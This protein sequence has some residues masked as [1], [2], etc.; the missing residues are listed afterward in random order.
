ML[1]LQRNRFIEPQEALKFVVTTAQPRVV[2]KKVKTAWCLEESI[3][4]TRSQWADSGTFYDTEEAYRKAFE[5][6]WA[7]A[8]VAH[9]LADYIRK[10]D[11]G[12]S[13]AGSDGDGID[14][15]SSEGGADTVEPTGEQLP[16]S[17]EPHDGYVGESS[18][19]KQDVAAT[20][21]RED[22]GEDG[23]GGRAV[24]VGEEGGA[25]AAS[26]ASG[27]AE[28]EMEV[29]ER[30]PPSDEIGD[31]IEEVKAVLWRHHKLIYS[32][33]DHYAII[34]SGSN[35][36][37]VSVGAF[38]QF[39]SDCKLAI[40]GSKHCS[41]AQFDQLFILVNTPEGGKKSAAGTKTLDRQEWLQC[42]VRCAVIR[43]VLPGTIPDVSSALDVL[44]TKDVR[45]NVHAAALQDSN[46]F[47]LG[48]CYIEQT[49]AVLL[50]HNASLRAIFDVY[51]GSDGTD[52]ATRHLAML[53]GFDEWSSL[54]RDMNWLDD[55]FTTREASFS[56]V[57]SRM[58][59]V[60]TEGSHSASKLQASRCFA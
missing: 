56:F 10:H 32:T 43:Y 36:T 3:W 39:A 17:P 29:E 12:E 34:G 22:D 9:K 28:K 54:I 35:F 58:R 16:T 46:A 4:K 42:L 57:W 23:G 40:K 25:G 11:D 7:R 60:D 47:R 18:T 37:Q 55:D 45:P 14:G 44:F 2:K 19:S 1:E 13:E 53:M 30:R 15:Q 27:D 38:K 49:D 5:T 59:V 20:Q 50:M 26:A 24:D 52:T 51:A 31:E 33:F 8:I 48:T 6:D 21:K 41:P